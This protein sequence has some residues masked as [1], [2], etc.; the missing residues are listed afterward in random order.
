MRKQPMAIFMLVMLSVPISASTARAAL[1]GSASPLVSA[2]TRHGWVYAL[3]EDGSTVRLTAGTNAYYPALSPDR[4][5]IAYFTVNRSSTAPGSRGIFLNGIWTVG[6][7]ANP[8]TLV[9]RLSGTGPSAL[10]WSPDSRLLAYTLGGVVT[11]WSVR[12]RVSTDVARP[13][14]RY[15]SPPAVAWSPGSH[16][17]AF[18]LASL[19]DKGPPRTLTIGIA[20]ISGQPFRTIRV[21]FPARLMTASRQAA[22]SHPDSG[23]IAWTADGSHLLVATDFNGEGY[24]ITGIWS[25]ADKGGVANLIVGNPAGRPFMDPPVTN[26]THFLV[27]PSWKYL[28]TDPEPHFWVAGVDGEQGRLLAMRQPV[29]CRISQYGWLAD[30]RGLAYVSVCPVL[31]SANLRFSLYI[32]RLLDGHRLLATSAAGPRLDEISLGPDW[33]CVECGF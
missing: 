14:K 9:S 19:P 23:Q 12:G 31:G 32:L 7:Q 6:T 18:P 1:P 24:G 10:A 30:S 26:A 8:Q 15:V 25:V 5:R 11:I 28:A 29:G 13:G 16:R 22:S 20:G 21:T 3:R 2:F 33:R 27:S 17:I 4:S